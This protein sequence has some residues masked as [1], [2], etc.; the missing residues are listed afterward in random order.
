MLRALVFTLL[1]GIGIGP[2]GPTFT[3][4]VFVVTLDI[5]WDVLLY[6]E[7]AL[8][9]GEGHARGLGSRP[10]TTAAN[11]HSYINCCQGHRFAVPLCRCAVCAARCWRFRRRPAH[12]PLAGVQVGRRRARRRTRDRLANLAA[13]RASS[14][15]SAAP[16]RRGA[17]SRIGHVGYIMKYCKLSQTASESSQS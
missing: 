13:A 2:V 9:L 3:L 15:L 14:S 7:L 12:R 5:I 17:R 8:V 11:Q 10:N 6:T 16:A 1:E 4:V